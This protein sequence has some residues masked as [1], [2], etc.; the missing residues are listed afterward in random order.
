MASFS[1]IELVA[2]IKDVIEV[3]QELESDGTFD[4]LVA[5]ETAIKTELEGNAQLKDLLTKIESFK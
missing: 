5:A 3:Y 4:K 2:A 1:P